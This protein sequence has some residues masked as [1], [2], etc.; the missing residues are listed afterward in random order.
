[1]E[2]GDLARRVKDQ[3]KQPDGGIEPERIASK[4]GMRRRHCD[5]NSNGGNNE[6]LVIAK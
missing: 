6:R 3:D 4:F 1:V 2:G 5:L